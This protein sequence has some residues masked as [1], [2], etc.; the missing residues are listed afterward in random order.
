M[1]NKFKIKTV[2]AHCD[3]PCGVYDPAQAKIEAQSVLAIQEKLAGLS[4]DD[5]T[6]AVQIKE[7]RA[8][9]VKH[10]LMVLW[11]DYFKPEH[12]DKYPDLHDK[13]WRALKQA[14][15]AKHHAEPES[16]K[17]LVEMIDGIADIFWETKQ[18]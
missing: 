7:Q 12:L 16:G 8:E 18:A 3:L 4:G 5:R 9:L 11:A 10:H 14:S 15:E 13:F 17:R 6:R 2:S 1:L